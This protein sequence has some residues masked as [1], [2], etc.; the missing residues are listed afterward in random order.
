MSFQNYCL[1]CYIRCHVLNLRLAIV[2]CLRTTPTARLQTRTY[3]IAEG[4]RLKSKISFQLVCY[5]QIRKVY[6]EFKVPRRDTDR[7]GRNLVNPIMT[8]RVAEGLNLCGVRNQHL[9]QN[10]SMVSHFIKIL[11]HCYKVLIYLTLG[12]LIGQ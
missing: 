12:L 1:D 10:P 5:D 2:F 3:L 11:R 9:Q 6:P 8:Q 7:F 4:I